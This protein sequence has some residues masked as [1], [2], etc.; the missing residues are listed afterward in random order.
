MKRYPGVSNH[1]GKTGH[2]NAEHHKASV[3]IAGGV[4]NKWG[5][6]PGG[7]P[8]IWQIH[9]TGC[10]VGKEMEYH[11]VDAALFGTFTRVVI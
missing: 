5:D 8:T 2:W 3:P 11:S 4:A 9:Y 7:L 1:A 6:N 10:K